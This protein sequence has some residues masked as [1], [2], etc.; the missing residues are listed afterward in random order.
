MESAHSVRGTRAVKRGERG[1]STRLSYQ[2]GDLYDDPPPS[3]MPNPGPL[4][5]E[6]RSPPWVAL[7]EESSKE[8]E[9]GDGELRYG[10]KCIE[11]RN[12][13]SEEEKERGGGGRERVG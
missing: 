13:D 6:D 7:A 12:L 9:A 11:A 4:A 5:A 1:Q 10:N 3:L 2:S 8:E